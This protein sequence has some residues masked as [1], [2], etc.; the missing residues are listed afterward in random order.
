[1]PKKILVTTLLIGCLISQEGHS[2]ALL[3]SSSAMSLDSERGVLS[4]APLLDRI[5]PAV[6]SINVRSTAKAPKLSN[7]NEEL[8]ERR[9]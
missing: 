8:L 5:T 4:M 2:Q 6:V 7:R 3:N 9:R 1:M